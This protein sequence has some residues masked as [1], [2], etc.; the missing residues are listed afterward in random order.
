[1]QKQLI[2]TQ[3]NNF[4]NYYPL[5][6]I[7]ESIESV[8]QSILPH[9][10]E[11]LSYM[12]LFYEELNLMIR[13]CASLYTQNRHK[14][15][16]ALANRNLKNLDAIVC[17]LKEVIPTGYIFCTTANSARIDL[18]II[19]DKY[20]YKP[21]DEMRS[22]LD[23]A[24]LGHQNINCTIH[25]YGTIYDMLLKGHLYYSAVCVPENCVYQSEEEFSLPSIN[26]QQYLSILNQSK[27][28]FKQNINKALSF[29]KCAKQFLNSDENTMAAFMLQ[30]ACELSFRSLLLSL[31]GKEVK[32]HD[33]IVLRKHLSH[34]DPS[35]I[36]MFD[37]N[38][39][40]ELNILTAIQ[41]AYIKARYDQNY[42]ISTSELI[43]L[44]NASEKFI[45]SAQKIF[46]NY[47]AKL[48]L[49]LN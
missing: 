34:F 1:M 26:K 39:Q 3:L 25:A 46:D 11:T 31:R 7:E 42:E 22:L 16:S 12:S 47:C 23:F 49:I 30:Q 45:Q 27:V 41:Q 44:I 5:E 37:E 10:L 38:E 32:C 15:T 48:M 14:F 20:K 33:L 9:P 29:F 6:F 28:I 4:F 40:E 13:N 2:E 8:F 18:L 36:G 17:F 35:I 43:K 21:F 19:M 24:M